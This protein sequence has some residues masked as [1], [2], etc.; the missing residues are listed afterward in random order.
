V[1][2][3]WSFDDPT[4]ADLTRETK[5]SLAWSAIAGAVARQATPDNPAVDLE[6]AVRAAVRPLAA[7]AGFAFAGVDPLSLEPLFE[8]SPSGAI[9]A[10]DDLPG[11]ARHLVA[12]GALT[13]RALFAAHTDE[14]VA[15]IDDA[16][17]HQDAITQRALLP[18]LCEA[19]P[20]VQWIVASKSHDVAASC[21]QSEVLALRRLPDADE[22]RLYEGEQALVH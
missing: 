1:K 6:R 22:V 5:A 16:E 11:A 15:L 9:V 3:V 4:R 17:L 13:A 19:L 14:G 18:A 10:F 12:F 8:A 7:L 20:G 2:T 21:S